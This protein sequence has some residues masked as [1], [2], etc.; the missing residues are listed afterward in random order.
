MSGSGILIMFLVIGGST[1][2]HETVDEAVGRSI[3]HLRAAQFMVDIKASVRGLQIGVAEMQLADTA[4]ALEETIAYVEARRKSI[5]G[6][7]SD[8]KPL[9]H[10]E[11]N[12]QLMA[13]VAALIADYDLLAHQLKDALR[14]QSHGE[15]ARLISQ[16]AEDAGKVASL[17]DFS[18]K[19]TKELSDAAL[20]EE[21]EIHSLSNT[22]GL[23]MALAMLSVMTASAVYGVRSIARPVRGLTQS[24]SNL[25]K[26]DLQEAIPFL[27]RGDEIGEMAQAVEVFKR[28]AIEVRDRNA[29]DAVLQAK[30]TELNASIGEVVAAAG[31]GDFTRRITK[32][33]GSDE[34]NHFAG[35]VNQ[36]VSS[37]DRGVAETSKVVS[38]LAQGDLTQ[39]MRGDFKGVFA[40][41]KGNVNTT[42]SNLRL[43]LGEVRSSVHAIDGGAG[44]VS[45]SSDDLSKRTGE[46]AAALEEASAAL[47]EITTSVKNSTKEV[48]EV[49]RM[50]HEAHLD[51]EQS[52]AVVNEAVAAMERIEN[53]SR[54]IGEIINIID[55]IA[56][57]T[58]L[59]AL[60][61]GV[62]AARAGDAGKGF[63]VVAQEV[64]ELAQRSADAAED[65]K[66]L[67][68]RSGHEVENGVKH[69]TATGE[70]LTSI[71]GHV[72]Q[73]NDYVRSIASAASQQSIGLGEVT[74]AVN[75]MDRGTQQNATMVEESAAAA[76]RLAGQAANLAT[77]I[78]RFKL[79]ERGVSPALPAAAA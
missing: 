13:E 78:T 64:R 36:L 44:E 19:K 53:A 79:D 35:Q 27:D 47:A 22:I 51:T 3:S 34:L 40:E 20:E 42:M 68:G 50:A 33:Y 23:I 41:L 73:I 7:F 37:V 65:I 28:N 54:E 8:L 46:Q 67:I 48:G 18:V 6:F 71:Q 72:A 38:A 39:E 56:F 15:A 24:M 60:N 14:A 16:L 76:N 17:I 11:E 26:G 57:Q 21:H 45:S 59:L 2:M 9:V 74:T 58:N 49:S 63:A 66:R 55:E 5:D 69:V 70:A 75:A 4:D 10:G 25:A 31:E 61:A 29:K 62:E 52:S 12:I 32:D 43:L 30:G 1:V 77:L